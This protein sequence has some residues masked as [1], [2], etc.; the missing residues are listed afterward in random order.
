MTPTGLRGIVNDEIAVYFCDAALAGAFA[1][2]WC[3]SGPPEIIEGA[4]VLRTDAPRPRSAAP[5]H[6]TPRPG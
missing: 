1:A 6:R 3:R 2:R 4:F 5:P